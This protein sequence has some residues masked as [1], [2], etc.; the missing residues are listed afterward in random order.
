MEATIAPTRALKLRTMSSGERPL[1]QGLHT[2]VKE[3]TVLMRALTSCFKLCGMLIKAI[4]G[5]LIADLV[6]KL[7]GCP[8]TLPS[9]F[10]SS[11]VVFIVLWVLISVR[12]DHSLSIS[13]PLQQ[14][15]SSYFFW[16]ATVSQI[17][18]GKQD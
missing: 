9:F 3:A 1:E 10:A 2:I 12:S 6:S 15:L 7:N 11:A 4:V 17:W 5:V 14:I 16:W 8:L 13:T 18:S